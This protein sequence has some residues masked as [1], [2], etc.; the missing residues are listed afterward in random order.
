MP[1][2]EELGLK[3][4]ERSAAREPQVFVA[5]NCRV[6]VTTGKTRRGVFAETVIEVLETGGDFNGKVIRARFDYLPADGGEPRLRA[7]VHS[8]RGDFT[9]EALN[10]VLVKAGELIKVEL[11]PRGSQ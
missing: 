11:P 7:R 8:R 1:I 10:E 9:T 3:M 5:A 6:T 4:G 2:G